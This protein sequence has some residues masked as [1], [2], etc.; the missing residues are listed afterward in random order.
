[1]ECVGLVGHAL[2]LVGLWRTRWYASPLSVYFAAY[3][4][5]LL[6][7]PYQDP[8]FLLPVLPLIGVFTILGLQGVLAGAWGR[9]LGWAYSAGFAALGLVALVL[10]SRVSLAGERFPEV[11]GSGEYADSYRAAFGQPLDP[12]KVLPDVVDLLKRY[13]PLAQK[14]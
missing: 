11:F 2:L 7:W 5:I 4:A 10:V 12:A 6:V 8:R 3:Y 14:R 13:E 1:M 9:G